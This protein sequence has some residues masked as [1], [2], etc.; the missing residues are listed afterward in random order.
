VVLPAEDSERIKCFADQV[1]MTH[2]LVRDLNEDVREI[3]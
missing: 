2:A 3:Q 1:K